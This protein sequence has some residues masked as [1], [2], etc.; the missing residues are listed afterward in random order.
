MREESVLRP[1]CLRY[2][3]IGYS[4]ESLSSNHSL[5]VTEMLC[6]RKVWDLLRG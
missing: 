4:Q 5:F 6:A 3:V 1:E 2:E